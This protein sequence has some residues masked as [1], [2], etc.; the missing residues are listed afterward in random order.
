MRSWVEKRMA[1]LAPPADWQP[2]AR[3]ALERFHA[4][5]RAQ[6]R[7][8]AW[9]DWRGW[10][11]AATLASVIVLL[12]PAGAHGGA[13]VLA[14]LDRAARRVHTR[15]S[16]AGGSA[17]AAGGAD[18][19][20]DPSAA[21]ARY[22][23]GPRAG[24]LRPAPTPPRCAGERSAALHHVR[25]VGGHDHPNGRPRTRAAEGRRDGRDRA[26][27]GTALPTG[28]AHQRDRHRPMARHSAGAKL[29]ADPERSRRVRLPRFLRDDF[30]RAG[31]RA[32]AGRATGWEGAG[33][34]PPWLAPIAGDL[35]QGATIE[36]ITL[37]S[38]PATLVQETGKSGAATRISLLWTVPDRVYLLSGTLSRELTI[39]AANAVE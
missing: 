8:G 5:M 12:L 29:A 35:M 9:L 33:T 15:E 23:R 13:T 21:R 25:L 27:G 11:V 14:V 7:R 26:G 37:D 16:V 10:A 38:G 39:A 6:P 30:A 31:R 28:A 19:R 3:A 22:G 2:D 17:V 34:V 4:R 1:G 24:A 18:R 32:G 36:E 20:A